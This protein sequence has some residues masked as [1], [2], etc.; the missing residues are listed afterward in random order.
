MEDRWFYVFYDNCGNNQSQRQMFC[1]SVSKATYK[2]ITYKKQCFI[3]Y[4][5][6]YASEKDRP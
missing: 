5:S 2:N 6:Q 1:G 4:I 3:P